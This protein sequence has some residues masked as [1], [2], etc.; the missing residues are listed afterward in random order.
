MKRVREE[1]AAADAAV[2]ERVHQLYANRSAAAC[3]AALTLDDGARPR[4]MLVTSRFTTVLQYAARDA[5]A[6]FEKLG[7]E[8]LTVIEAGPE[9]RPFKRS[10]QRQV[11]GV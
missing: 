11:A 1:V 5:A 6:A 3:A 9:E 4:V 7:C 2:D 10:L 8:T